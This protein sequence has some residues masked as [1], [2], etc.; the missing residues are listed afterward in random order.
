M[1]KRRTRG[2]KSVARQAP[3]NAER[4]EIVRR[5]VT[6]LQE[7]QKQIGKRSSAMV[8]DVD[9]RAAIAEGRQ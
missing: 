2:S 7:L 4:P 9:I 6:G 5:A 3:A 8:S 1:T